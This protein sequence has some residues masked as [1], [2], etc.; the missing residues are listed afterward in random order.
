MGSF[1]WV[2]LSGCQLFSQKPIGVFKVLKLGRI[3][4]TA[5]KKET[6]V[7]RSSFL[8]DLFFLAFPPIQVGYFKASNQSQRLNWVGVP[9]QVWV[10]PCPKNLDPLAVHA[11]PRA[12]HFFPFHGLMD[13]CVASSPGMIP[14]AV[15]GKWLGSDEEEKHQLFRCLPLRF[16]LS[17]RIF[18]AKNP[19]R[20]KP[21]RD[22]KKWDSPSWPKIMAHHFPVTSISI[23]ASLWGYDIIS[24]GASKTTLAMYT[25]FLFWLS[26]S[27]GVWSFY[28]Q[29]CFFL[30]SP[31]FFSSGSVVFFKGP[32]FLNESDDQIAQRIA[33]DFPSF[34]AP[35]LETVAQLRHQRTSRA[36]TVRAKEYHDVVPLF[37]VENEGE[38]V[39]FWEIWVI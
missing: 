16:H 5:T 6:T 1:T 24:E 22:G 32:A 26:K 28:F 31:C 14:Q 29:I 11:V 38:P 9:W 25:S 37:F 2:V 12:W 36:T 7:R 13:A 30:S 33:E 34:G 27:R 3:S 21:P 17:Q 20:H 39:L 35:T 15:L 8:V 4:K 18:Y 10:G 23:D 19:I